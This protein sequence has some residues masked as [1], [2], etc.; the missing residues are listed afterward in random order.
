MQH[1]A[2]VGRLETVGDTGRDLGG[3]VLIHAPAGTHQIAQR[4]AVDELH[5]DERAIRAR[6][7]IEHANDIGVVDGAKGL[8]LAMKTLDELGVAGEFRPH[9]LQGDVALERAIVRAEDVS[10]PS[11]PDPLQELVAADDETHAASPC[12][13]VADLRILRP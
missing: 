6:A 5:R 12:K 1:A 8:G 10:H 3:R 13:R 9:H 2:D 7:E 4:S 11:P